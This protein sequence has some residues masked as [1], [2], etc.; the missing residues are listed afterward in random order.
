M[1][2]KVLQ[3]VVVFG[4]AMFRDVLYRN[5]L[6]RNAVQRNVAQRNAGTSG[7]NDRLM[8]VSEGR[9]AHIGL[10]FLSNL[11][12]L[13]DGG[14]EVTVPLSQALTEER[15]KRRLEEYLREEAKELLREGW[16]NE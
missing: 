3:G 1:L 9:V 16:Q 5:V 12:T 10:R 4:N 7:C 15:I 14:G 13:A 8:R 2:S 11:G 6:F